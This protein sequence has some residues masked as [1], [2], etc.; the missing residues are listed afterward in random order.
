MY[1]NTR[2]DIQMAR[3]A[4]N[5]KIHKQVKAYAA[6]NGLKMPEAYEE[7]LTKSLTQV[8]KRGNHD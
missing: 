1:N 2:K 6:L 8:N 4:V 3:I 5:E 7:L